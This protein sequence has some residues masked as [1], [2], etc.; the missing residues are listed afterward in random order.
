ME[1]KAIEKASTGICEVD[2]GKMIPILSLMKL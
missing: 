1:G 2:T